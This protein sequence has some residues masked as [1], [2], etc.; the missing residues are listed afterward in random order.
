MGLRA[1]LAASGMRSAGTAAARPR[2]PR[3]RAEPPSGRASGTP[4]PPAGTPG[5]RTATSAGR[6]RR[7]AS[8]SAH[9]VPERGP[10]APLA[11]RRRAG[12]GGESGTTASAVP[13]ASRMRAAVRGRWPRQRAD[14]RPP[15][16]RAD[17]GTPAGCEPGQRDR[18]SGRGSAGG[19]GRNVSRVSRYGSA[20][21]DVAMSTAT[22][23]SAA[24]PGSPRSRPSNDPRRRPRV[25]SGRAEQRRKAATV[26]SPNSP[27]VSGSSSGGL[28]PWPRTSKARQW[29]PAAWRNCASGRVRSRADS[30]P[31]T[32]TMPGPGAPSRAGIE[33]R[34]EVQSGRP[35]GRLLVGQPAGVGHGAGRVPAREAG[36][37]AVREREPVGEAH[38]RGRGCRQQPGASDGP[39]PQ[40][41]ATTGGPVKRRT[42]HTS[43]SAIRTRSSASSTTPPRRG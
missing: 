12:P 27:A 6:P 33:P 5:T 31:W 40:G 37:D 41:D 30:Q 25:T 3:A 38:R 36:P 10:A 24:R 26:S 1:L 32:R 34:R 29:N 43:R 20:G 14:P 42:L 9:R 22:R 18:R 13:W 16:G 17:A 39:M 15:G 11:P 35:D 7:G 28:P 23:G 21:V 4:P 8:R 19:R 2:P